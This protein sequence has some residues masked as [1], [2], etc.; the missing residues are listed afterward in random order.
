MQYK[1][2][3]TS[4]PFALRVVDQFDFALK[5][6]N[7]LAANHQHPKSIAAV[8]HVYYPELMPEIAGCLNNFENCPDLFISTDTPEKAKQIRDFCAGYPDW[9]ID[10]RVVENRGRDVAPMFV[11]FKDIFYRY[12]YCLHLHTKKTQHNS[13]V[14]NWRK[15]LF[16]TLC[17]SKEIVASNLGLL[18]DSK[19][20]FI[21][22]QNIGVYRHNL[23]WGTRYFN[24]KQLLARSGIEIFKDTLLEF[25]SSTMFFARTMALR[26]LIEQGLQ[27]TDFDIENKQI[28]ATLAH[29]IETSLLYFVENSGYKSVKISYNHGNMVQLNQLDDLYK[30]LELIPKLLV[31]RSD[32]YAL[33]TGQ[34]KVNGYG[35]ICRQKV[36]NAWQKIAFR[37]WSTRSPHR[38]QIRNIEDI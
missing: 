31:R 13:A 3:F 34:L 35:E 38:F 1:L 26:K 25:P 4:N 19:V 24:V 32:V 27:L 8:I 28:T 29:D 2:N 36:F 10:L 6:P 21:Y 33:L 37:F 5:I 16:H 30:Y 12:E 7:I 14:A 9:K 11:E 15:Y 23:S 17:G 18:L 22:A 20:G